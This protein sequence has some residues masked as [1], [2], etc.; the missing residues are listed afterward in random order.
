MIRIFPDILYFLN[1]ALPLEL[2]NCVNKKV[3]RVFKIVFHD[4]MFD[5]APHSFGNLNRLIND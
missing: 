4:L 5:K 3:F 1:I 2:P